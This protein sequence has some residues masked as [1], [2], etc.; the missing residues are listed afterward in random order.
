MKDQHPGGKGN[1]SRV[2]NNLIRRASS[3]LGP[4]RRAERRQ[5]LRGQVEQYQGEKVWAVDKELRAMRFEY[6]TVSF[7]EAP[8]ASADQKP[9]RISEDKLEGSLSLWLGSFQRVFSTTARA[10]DS[11]PSMAVNLLRVQQLW[12]ESAV[13]GAEPY[14]LQLFIGKWE[15]KNKVFCSARL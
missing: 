4:G 8:T 15:S 7:E 6:G 2:K 11:H 9:A 3:L 14:V 12:K 10:G 5:L 1:K 13:L